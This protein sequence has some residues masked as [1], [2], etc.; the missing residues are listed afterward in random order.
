MSF[1]KGHKFYKGGEK[2]WFP[3]GKKPW[4]TGKKL[5][6]KLRK[7]FSLS[8]IGI[9]NGP[10]SEETKHK[11]S[12]SAMGINNSQWKGGRR[13][14]KGRVLI[15]SNA[16]PLKT[17]SGYVYEHRLVMEKHLGRYLRPE[18]VVHHIN[19]VK[20]D[21]RIENLLLL[22]NDIEH[23]RLHHRMGRRKCE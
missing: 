17:K 4:N 9:S 7:I 10:C 20:D 1:K 15:L 6:K 22:P 11:M 14:H 3:K 12:I 18:E 5:S 19:Q 16:H 23:L 13:Y 2:G 21:N 8:H